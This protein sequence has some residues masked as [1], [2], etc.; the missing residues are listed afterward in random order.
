VGTVRRFVVGML[1]GALVNRAV[2]YV[3]VVK[4]GRSCD[5]LTLSRQLN[6]ILRMKSLIASLSSKSSDIAG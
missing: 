2:A 5:G 6:G 1:T 3:K 4:V